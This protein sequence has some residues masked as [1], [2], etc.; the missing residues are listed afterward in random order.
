MELSPHI[1]EIQIGA[2]IYAIQQ[3]SDWQF[4]YSVKLIG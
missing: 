4:F 1:L 2:Y 3:N